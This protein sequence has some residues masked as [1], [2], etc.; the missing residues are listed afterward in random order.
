MNSKHTIIVLAITAMSISVY[1]DRI[2]PKP[3]RPVVYQGVEYRA[4]IEKMG[5]VQAWKDGA[6]LWEKQV[7]TI[8][9][10]PILEKDV[11]DVF[12]TDLQIANN[13]LTVRN[14]KGQTFTI[15]MNREAKPHA[16]EK[17]ESA[18]EL[19]VYAN[20]QF[21]LDLYAQLR[22]QEGNL[23]LS[24]YSISTALAMTYAGA[25]DQT[26]EQ[27]AQTL[28]FSEYIDPNAPAWQESFHPVF[29]Q[30]IEQL[31]KQGQKGDYN[32]S[33]ANALW[34]QKNYPFLESFTALNNRCY[35][36]GLENVDFV[37]ETE[38]SRLKI[39]Q[40]VEDKTQDKIKDLISA[41]VLDEGT[42]LV[43]TNA[44]YFKGDWASQFDKA[45][46]TEQDFRLSPHKT[47][48]SPL[49][50]QTE[51]FNYA[52]NDLLQILE[53]PYKGNDLSMLVL[54]PRGLDNTGKPVEAE[55][56]SVEVIRGKDR[57]T[58]APRVASYN[59]AA[60]EQNLTA[61]NLKTWQSRMRKREVKV[62][63]P[64]FKMTRQFSLSQTLAEMGMPDA[65]EPGSA[66]FSGMTGTK[67]LFISAVLHKA[68]VEVNEEGTEAAAATGVA[69][70]ATA[71]PLAPPVFRADHPFV[72]IIKDKTCGSILF[73]GRVADPTKEQ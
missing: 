69:I 33:V 56:P 27:M 59:L 31:N 51:E 68:F 25:K 57:Q 19:I 73:V 34:G 38:A 9:Y 58:V 22:T 46:T 8:Q 21:A 64:K 50:C 11:Q 55:Q 2:L 40:W 6:L 36:A 14:E 49:M 67:D 12:I 72:F 48:K 62:F 61:D 42:R 37:N 35:H 39:N 45:A 28:H 60:V 65:F 15:D 54:L 32:L 52:E 47:V 20:S 24:P 43:L 66:D 1:A 70:A 41:G 18:K 23:F 53:L 29:G 7:Y 26:A 63:L 16:E 71:M 5:Y 13:I 4:P 30:L 17:K 3:V 10:N 44:I